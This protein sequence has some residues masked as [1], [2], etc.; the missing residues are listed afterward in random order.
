MNNSF[1]KRVEEN[2]KKLTK[3]QGILAEYILKNYKT[4]AFLSSVPLG[5]KA[6]VSE[7]T[8]IRFARAL[9]YNGFIDMIKDIQEHVKN[10]ITTIDKLESM[11]KIYQNKTIFDEVIN[12][13]QLIIRAIKRSITDDQIERVVKAMSQCKK[14]VVVGHES[15][16]SSADYLGYHLVRIAPD[17]ETIN[18]INDNVLNIVKKCDNDTYS[19]II[20]FPRYSRKTLEL[21]KIFKDKGAQILVITDSIM[22][23]IAEY[24]DDIFLI[25]KYDSINTN[26]DVSVGVLT[27]IQVL[28]MEYGSQNYK[29]AKENLEKTEDFNYAYSVFF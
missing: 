10:E 20:A 6:G 13:N 27:I 28:I 9:G 14:I 26:L 7:A 25:P 22:A 1:F 15:S 4:A 12:N 19:I 21:A 2:R 3:K 23:P 5:E 8:V 18:D 16:S 17:V 11:G 24:C 29:Q